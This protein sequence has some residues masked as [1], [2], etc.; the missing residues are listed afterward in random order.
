MNVLIIGSGMYVT[1]RD[2]TGTGTILSALVQYHKSHGLNKIVVVS[3]SDRSAEVVADATKRINGLLSTNA[4]VEFKALGDN[5]DGVIAELNKTYQF[6]AA[7]IAL[8]DHLHHQFGVIALKNGIHTLMVKPFTPTLQ[9]AVDLTDL[10][11]AKGLFGCVEF[12]KRYDETNLWIKKA[13]GEQRLGKLNY[14]Q[15]D[16]SQRID[17][18][19]KTFTGWSDKSNIMQYLGVHYVDLFYFLTGAK[20]IRISGLG[21]DGVLKDNGINTYDSTHCT[22]EW[23]EKSGNKFISI[24][25][26]NWIDPNCSSALSDQKYKVVGTVGRIECDQ[27][28]RGVELVTPSTG[29]QQI[30]PYFSDYLPDPNGETRFSGYGYTSIA[31]FMDD[32][33]NLEAGKVSLDQLTKNRPSFTDSLV[34]TAVVEAANES[35]MNNG[36]W[37]PITLN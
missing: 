14:F 8:P 5:P 19:M 17:I 26:T 1:G 21:T 7:I 12:H 20:P 30:N 10:A 34:S 29:I 24:H 13:L 37:T 22:I 32:V 36:A 35:M 31:I 28:N 9:E 15:V 16:Y 11:K 2:N 3:K 4:V 18:P 27:K 33:K 6:K 25:N 23:E